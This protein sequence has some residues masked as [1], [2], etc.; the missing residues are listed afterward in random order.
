MRT[1]LAVSGAKCH[2][3]ERNGMYLIENKLYLTFPELVS[4]GISGHT[5]HSARTR[6]SINWSFLKDPL[7]KRLLLVSGEGLGVLYEE[8]VIRHYGNPCD[9]CREQQRKQNALDALL[10]VPPEEARAIKFPP[11]EGMPW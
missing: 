8:K 10:E 1:C 11:E 5:I 7:D 9:H 4:A 6:K 3:P 2:L